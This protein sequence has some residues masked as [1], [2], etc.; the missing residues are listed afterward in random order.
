MSVLAFFI[1]MALVLMLVYSWR[2]LPTPMA[3]VVTV[4]VVILFVL[5]GLIAAQIKQPPP[6]IG[7]RFN[8]RFKGRRQ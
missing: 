7:H 4:V 1:S 3:I 5:M 8:P 6:T 2:D